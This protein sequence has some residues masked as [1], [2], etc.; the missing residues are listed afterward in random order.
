V[1]ALLLRLL[2]LEVRLSLKRKRKR[3]WKK[4]FVCGMPCVS[5]IYFF[6]Q[7]EESDDDMGFGLFD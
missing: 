7:E 3:R 1:E 2:A 5:M 4:R 6:F